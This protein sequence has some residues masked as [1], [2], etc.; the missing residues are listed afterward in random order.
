MPDLL[1]ELG[2]DAPVRGTMVR[3]GRKYVHGQNL[4]SVKG[5]SRGREVF[6][7]LDCV[8]VVCLT[9]RKYARTLWMP[10]KT[11]L[12]AEGFVWYV[13]LRIKRRASQPT[14]YVATKAGPAMTRV[15]LQ[16]LLVMLDSKV[17]VKL[18]DSAVTRF[19]EG[20][21]SMITEFDLDSLT[22]NNK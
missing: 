10:V 14:G 3:D 9:P 18:Q 15:G 2:G 6:S 13:P 21:S 1:V 11:A 22:P 19:L 17:K 4:G 5:S 7:P 8:A 16:R 12:E 20:E